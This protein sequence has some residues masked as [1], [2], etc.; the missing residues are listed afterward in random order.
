MAPSSVSPPSAGGGPSQSRQQQQQQKRTRILLSCHPCRASK[1][2]CDR[3][4]PCANCARRG[5][6][7]DCAYAPPPVKKPRSRGGVAARLKRLE[8]MV[9]EMM[10]N[11][12]GGEGGHG[13]VVGQQKQEPDEVDAGGGRGDD[14]GTREGEQQRPELA[15]RERDPRGGDGTEGG[16]MVVGKGRRQATYVGATHFMAMLD[17]IEDLKSYFDADADEDQKMHLQAHGEWPEEPSEA[18]SPDLLFTSAKDPAT[19]PTKLDLVARLPER[20]VVDRLVTRYFQSF[21][22]SKCESRDAVHKPTFLRKYSKFWEDPSQ[23]ETEW[24]AL[25]FIILALSIF[26]STWSSPHELKADSPVPPTDRFSHFRA[27]ARWALVLSRYTSPSPAVLAPFLLYVESE[28]LIS[29][30]AQTNCYLLSGCLIRLMLKMG[31]HRDPDRLPALSPYE[32]ELRRR[33]WAL[34]VQL[35]RLV[36]FHTGLP[37]MVDGV[38][39]DAALPRN[40]ADEDFD[41]HT[42]ELPPARPDT[43]YTHM[44]YAICKARV[45]RAFGPVARLAH[46]L[47]PPPPYAEVLRLDAELDAA[48]ASVPEFMRVR[49]PEQCLADPP[50]Q[51]VHRYGI[52]SLYQKSRC[53]LHRRYLVEAPAPRRDSSSSSGEHDYSRRACLGAALAL[54]GY[55]GAIFE[56]TRPG[57]ALSEHGWF[58]TGIAMHDFLL[59]A[60]V[61]YLVVQNI[62]DDDDVSPGDGEEGTDRHAW[63]TEEPALPGRGELIALLYRSHAIWEAISRESSDVKKAA[64]ILQMMV[65]KISNPGSSAAAATA[66]ADDVNNKMGL[67]P[68]TDQDKVSYPST[69]PTFP[70]SDGT[71]T[72]T[73]SMAAELSHGNTFGNAPLASLAT[74]PQINFSR[75]DL[76]ATGFE[77]MD[78]SADDSWI[79]MTS[80]SFDWDFLD[81]GLGEGVHVGA[82]G[83]DTRPRPQQGWPEGD[84]GSA[85]FFDFTNASFWNQSAGQHQ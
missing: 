81:K 7:A 54:L 66:V 68:Q 33:M 79:P 58:A 19:A 67:T 9:R 47:S 37:C 78:Y 17:D 2:K 59:A 5:R 27:S 76:V 43:E 72:G 22:V 14:G 60:M 44:T 24:L 23:V 15:G 36:S 80:A 10:D 16:T 52:A 42:T 20:H 51:S 30:A 32:G 63:M 21:S 73:G 25:L 46:R 49:P 6:A 29:R 45:F 50:L 77:N 48:Y 41:E 4:T 69:G 65:N 74:P 61:V 70:T 8:G 11:D 3:A 64:D 85:D 1:L 12:E 31:L 26:F 13:D 55:Q 34:A 75:A 57:C 38:D 83:A 84:A 53:V 39:A 82:M 28:F 62:G 71:G 35:E 18:G 56:A 40:L